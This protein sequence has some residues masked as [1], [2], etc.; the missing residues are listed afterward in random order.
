MKKDSKSLA[1]HFIE[2]FR[3]GGAA[4]KAGNAIRKKMQEKKTAGKKIGQA[5]STGPKFYEGK[6]PPNA[7]EGEKLYGK[8][9]DSLRKMIPKER[10]D[11]QPIEKK[12]LK[13]KEAPQRRYYA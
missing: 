6:A 13:K 10:K 5:L 2:K 12:P 8:K 11:F 7:F 4:G 1:K 9:R 3:I